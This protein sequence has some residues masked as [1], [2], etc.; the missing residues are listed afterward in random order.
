MKRAWSAI[1]VAGVLVM[2]VAA[3]A[4]DEIGWFDAPPQAGGAR[5]YWIA[6]PY[7][8]IVLGMQDSAA[9]SEAMLREAES[10]GGRKVL[11]ALMLTAAP[12]QADGA[13]A[14]MR[15]GVK[16]YTGQQV[17]DALLTAPRASP[18]R[19]RG[20]EPEEAPSGP[21][22]VGEGVHE[23]LIAGVPLR[24]RPL[25]AGLAPAHLVVEHERD[26]FVGDL[27]ASQ[28][29]PALRGGSLLDWFKRLQELLPVKAQRVYA[30]HGEPGAMG[31]IWNQMIYIRQVMGFIADEHPAGVMPPEAAARVKQKIVEAYPAHAA[32]ER[33]DALIAA[34]WKR[35]AGGGAGNSFRQ[36][37]RP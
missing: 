14:L 7:G 15:R 27:V 19:G 26:L 5:S 3:Q 1:L 33:L 13:A 12:A 16:V 30:A 9:Q 2:S 28:S 32:P 4:A 21:V 11:M 29:H 22:S 25:G 34:E 31:L 36:Q 23:M 18:G 24:L 6:G 10:R 20:R 35:Q 8:S 37:D 17:L